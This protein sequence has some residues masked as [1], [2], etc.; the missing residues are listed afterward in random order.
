MVRLYQISG[1]D[2]HSRSI[3]KGLDSYSG[4]SIGGFMLHPRSRGS[5]H[6]ASSD[7]R[8]HP[9]IQPNYLSCKEDCDAASGLLRLARAIASQPSL[10]PFVVAERRPGPD[11]N[12][13]NALQ[14]YI[15]QSG[16]TAW[17]TVGTCRMGSGSNSVVDARLRVRGVHALRVIDASVMPS[18]PS[19]NTNAPAIM[20]GEKGAALVLEDAKR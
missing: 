16:Q 18:I 2:R 6:I 8:E 3:E 20:I 10:R 15:R 4:F 12:D 19:T 9:K 11:V 17:H 14:E 1:A 7:P 5:L 13:E